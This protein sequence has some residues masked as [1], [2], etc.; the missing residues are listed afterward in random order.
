MQ[1]DSGV[2]KTVRKARKIGRT[3]LAK[4][5]GLTERQITRIETGQVDQVSASD[6]SGLVV[7]LE[8][9]LGVLMGE[10]ALTEQDLLPA[11]EVCGSGCSCC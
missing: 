4:M 1:I 10:D 9:P 6:M 7:A 8:V 2:L 5:S 3:R 11:S